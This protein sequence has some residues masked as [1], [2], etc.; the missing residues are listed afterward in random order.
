MVEFRWCQVDFSHR[1]CAGMPLPAT[2][3]SRH[4]DR[5]FSFCSQKACQ[6]QGLLSKLYH[7]QTSPPKVRGFGNHDNLN[8]LALLGKFLCRFCSCWVPDHDIYITNYLDLPM[9]LLSERCKLYPSQETI[10]NS[11]KELHWK[12]QVPRTSK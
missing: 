12:V 6:D 5:L 2:A 11:K 1:F 3:L 7:I 4:P 9:Q 10:T 8:T